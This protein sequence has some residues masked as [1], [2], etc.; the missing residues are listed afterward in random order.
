MSDDAA[1]NNFTGNLKWDLGGKNFTLGIFKGIKLAQGRLVE[2][3]T[4]YAEKNGIFSL[5][6]AIKPHKDHRLTATCVHAFVLQNLYST[7]L[8]VQHAP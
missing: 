6:A 3:G 8:S 1:G 4:S 7:K 5:E 2:L